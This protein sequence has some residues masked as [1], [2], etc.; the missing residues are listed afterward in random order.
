ML[1]GKSKVQY[2]LLFLLLAWSAIAQSIISG[3][4]IYAQ[5]RGAGSASLLFHVAEDS[6]RLQ[7][8]SSQMAHIGLRP[9]DELVAIEGELIHGYRQLERKRFQFRPGQQVAVTIRRQPEGQPPKMMHMMVPVH[10][11]A[12]HALRWIFTVVMYTIL[13]AFSLLLGYWV[14]LSRP[15]DA[16]AWL[17]LAVLASFS[18][19]VPG[20]FFGLDAPWLQIVV[21]YRSLLSNTWPLWIMLF[22]LYF[23][24]P[25]PIFRK[26][27]Y[28][29]YLLA[30][31]F[32]LLLVVD[33]YTD[34][35]D[36]TRI[37]A[38]QNLAR[39]E[40]ALEDPLSIFFMACTGSFLVS[41]ALKLRRSRQPDA[42]RRLQWLLVGSAA[43]LI[44]SLLLEF[45]LNILEW[46]LPG[47][48]VTASILAITLFPLTL[49]Y[50]IVVQRAMEVRVAVRLGVKYA[51]ARSGLIVLRIL[52]SSLI[53]VTAI[54]LALNAT[55]PGS[56]SVLIGIAVVLLLVLGKAGR[57]LSEWTDRRFFRED[58]DA[59]VIL[60][61]LAQNVATI[62]ETT[63]LLE[64]VARRISDSLHVP[65][66]AVLLDSSETL[67]PA[68]ALGI[69]ALP[70]AA[71]PRGGAA[72]QKLKQTRQAERVYFDDE[73]SWIQ[74]TSDLERAALRA[75]DAQLLLPLMA[76]DRLLGII[77]LGPKR[78]EEPY[79]TTDIRL[80]NAVASQTALALENA[81][82]TERI[83][84]EIA[85][86]A[87]VN[88]ELEI[89]REVQ[90]RLF[91]QYLPEVPGLDYAGYCRPQQEVG[92]DYYDFIRIGECSL[93]IAI[94]DVS[95][96]GIGASLMMAT[97]QASL[98][99]QALRPSG[100][101]AE[102]VSLINRLVYDGST[103][104]RY[105][106]FFYGQYNP[107]TRRL[108]YVNAGHN[109]P[110]VFRHGCNG[111]EIF[112]LTRG[113]TVLGLFPDA[114]YEEGRVELKE[115]DSLVAFTDGISEAMNP[116][117]EEW[118]EE[119]L[120]QA[121]RQC[122]SLCATK[123][124]DDILSRVDTFTA[125]AK[126]YDD[127]TLVVMRLK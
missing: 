91:P 3:Y 95:G 52:L 92:G 123:T 42:R 62:R 58:Y 100:G 73:T 53:I 108:Q 96:K 34:Y 31:P 114:K 4:E 63:P 78:S 6:L 59:E 99:T 79:S 27:R 40:K 29:P 39:V 23:P 14:A 98:R 74:H 57:T 60:T 18:Q 89:A 44:P 65:R 22:G 75:L 117:Q 112:R 28:I 16:L 35:Y 15:R 109:A 8:S 32:A 2:S 47:W 56:A 10:E 61:E 19:L 106:T 103:S 88:R 33:F 12:R 37:E 86:R 124:I 80:L 70:D 127:M 82:L 125:G 13:P 46:K 94:G 69:E 11:P 71:L 36:A 66:V 20:N 87:R 113:G 121:I 49:A 93:G 101:P 85:E 30:I 107:A 119:R 97:L 26:R 41:I 67:R 77:S 51:L 5:N 1:F 116:H 72:V 50:V 55:G 68:Y 83:R 105:A 64:T 111:G 54:K 118:E 76:N 45:L 120:I 126:Q 102:I 81:R 38:I 84:R 9:G 25:F 122:R 104:N 110:V 24:K 115:G 17:T 43:A 7:G 21:G 48:Y 90:E